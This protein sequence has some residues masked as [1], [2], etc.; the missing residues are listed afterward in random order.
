[1]LIE[2]VE[3]A[4]PILLLKGFHLLKIILT[5]VGI[6]MRGCI[7]TRNTQIGEIGGPAP[8]RW[9]QNLRSGIDR[10]DH[11]TIA[12]AQ[13]DQFIIARW[14]GMNIMMGPLPE[15]RFIVQIIHLNAALTG[16]SMSTDKMLYPGLL[17]SGAVGNV[18]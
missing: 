14:I 12:L 15:I 3:Q 10:F 5:E 11:G 13:I 9:T 1:M 7:V 6:A 4:V 18:I 16:R 8:V 2:V 17:K